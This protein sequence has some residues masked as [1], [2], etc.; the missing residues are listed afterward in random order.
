MCLL[1]VRL[2]VLT[3]VALELVDALHE[4]GV[5]SLECL[6]SEDCTPVFERRVD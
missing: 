4:V 2:R 5:M 1:H 6:N 3:P